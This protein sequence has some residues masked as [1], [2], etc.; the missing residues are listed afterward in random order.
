MADPRDDLEDKL[1][2]RGAFGR[3]RGR[4]DV[5][6]PGSPEP[7]PEPAAELDGTDGSGG[8]DPAEVPPIQ[9]LTSGPIPGMHPPEPGPTPDVE[10]ASES[11]EA[12]PT[13]QQPSPAPATASP[14]PPPPAGRPTGASEREAAD[15]SATPWLERV[16]F[17][18][19]L[20][21]RTAAIVTGVVVGLLG[22][23]L[24]AIGLQGCSSVRGTTACGAPG[25]FVLVAILAVMVLLGS[26]LLAYWEIA[27]S[28]STS[29]LAVA[30]VAV[31]SLLVLVDVLFSPWM[32]LVVPALSAAAYTASW[33]VTDRF[34]DEDLAAP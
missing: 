6:S 28:G 16:D 19:R 33:Y 3:K 10:A 34:D 29:F 27:N 15:E 18:P 26:A 5:E 25:F 22:T 17:L 31:L 24:T 32:F 21:G 20:T 8:D 11:A 13:P 4:R 2:L 7:S 12:S 30:L 23:A 9:T 14:G 1:T